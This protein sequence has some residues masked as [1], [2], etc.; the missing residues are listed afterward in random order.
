MAVTDAQATAFVNTKIRPFADALYSAIASAPNI[1]SL[2]YGGV[3][4]LIPNTT[5]VVNDGASVNGV[6]GVGGDGRRVLTGA[7]VNNL[8]NRI[9]EM[10]NYVGNGTLSAGAANPAVYQQIQKA[11]VNGKPLS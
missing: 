4:T 2:W 6:D 7:D 11:V 5:A 8:M 3:N 9:I 1:L 10:T